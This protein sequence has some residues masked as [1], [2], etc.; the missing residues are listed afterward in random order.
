[1]TSPTAPRAEPRTGQPI[2]RPMLAAGVMLALAWIAQIVVIFG[3]G[4]RGPALYDEQHFHLPTIRSFAEQLPAPDLSD[5]LV[6]TSPGYHLVMA[7]VERALALP[8]QG[9]RLIGGQFAVLAVVLLAW[10]F[11]RRVAWWLAVALAVPIWISPYFFASSVLALPEGAAWL[12]VFVILML[13][14][15]PR[16]SASQLGLMGLVLVVL[17]AVRQIH[18]WAAATIWLVGWLGPNQN[19]EPDRLVPRFAELQIR[20]RIPP[21]VLSVAVTL[22]AF[23]L[24]AYFFRLWDGAVPPTFQTGGA[25]NTIE[26]AAEHTGFNPATPALVFATFGAFGPFFAL[27][28]VG[29]I[30]RALA[31]RESS[32]WLPILFGL[33][34]L[35]LA[36]V[37]ATG[38]DEAAG[39][40]TGLWTVAGRLPTVADRS[41]LIAALAG[42]GGVVLGAMLLAV[43]SRDRL[44]LLGSL[45]A[46]TTAQSANHQSWGRYVNAFVL[47]V[48]AM[49]VALAVGRTQKVR[50]WVVLGPGVLGFFLLAGTAYRLLG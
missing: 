8:D 48:L 4:Y 43:S 36:V 42:I 17:V 33:V 13:A 3:V 29:P 35:M 9:L 49:M 50:W 14:L 18:L 23:V 6:A 31:A 30:R 20:K 44:V 7:A 2:H 5:Y 11:G 1:M 15:R 16:V 19:P 37:P 22:P 32:R 25:A 12:G 21:T 47:V 46:F 34:G 27:G 38:F 10:W 45:V 24:V 41:V 28:L 26:G 40:W 39:R